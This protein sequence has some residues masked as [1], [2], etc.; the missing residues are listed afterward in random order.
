MQQ[1]PLVLAGNHDLLTAWML[2][3]LGSGLAAL[4]GD[5]FGSLTRLGEVSAMVCDMRGFEPEW[6]D[7]NLTHVPQFLRG[8]PVL[9]I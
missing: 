9:L 8:Q 1:I 5:S 2:R 6:H 4:F 7:C 3:E